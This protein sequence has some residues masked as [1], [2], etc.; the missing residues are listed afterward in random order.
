MQNRNTDNKNYFGQSSPFI[1]TL[2]Q[3][4]H[5]LAAHK[6]IEEAQKCSYIIISALSKQHW[7]ATIT[8]RHGPAIFFN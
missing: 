4:K 6:N 3:F 5:G 8:L 1:I 7:E 2:Y